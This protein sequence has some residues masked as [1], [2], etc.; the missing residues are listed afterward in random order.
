ME[1]FKPTH[2]RYIKLGQG[3]RWEDR[4]INHEN[5]IM[6]GYES[7]YHQESLAGNWQTVHDYWLKTRNGRK[8]VASRD[9]NQI[10]DFYEM[11]RSC[12]WVTFHARFL[13]WCFADE[14]I[15]EL[16]DKTN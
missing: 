15:K 6:L 8:G 4:C 2:V 13:Y 16:I 1:N 9:V 11:P 5:A 7:S 10:R 3:G 14:K 12:L